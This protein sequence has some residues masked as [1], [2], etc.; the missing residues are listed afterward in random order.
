M[1]PKID[2]YVV[3]CLGAIKIHIFASWANFILEPTAFKSHYSCTQ[4]SNFILT[5]FR[6]K[7]LEQLFALFSSADS[8][9][10]LGRPS[11]TRHWA[12]EYFEA[13]GVDRCRRNHRHRHFH[14]KNRLQRSQR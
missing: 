6:S 14:G 5:L 4:F 3:K 7:F 1:L 9:Q 11:R 10:T 13:L 2:S 12:S 8:I